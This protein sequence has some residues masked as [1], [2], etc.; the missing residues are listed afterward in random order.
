M[1]RRSDMNAHCVSTRLGAIVVLLLSSAC[2]VDVSEGVPDD[3]GAEPTITQGTPGGRTGG[4]EC[5][6]VL[7]KD[8]QGA[9]Y[10]QEYLCPLPDRPI[11]DP[12]EGQALENLDN[13]WVSGTAV[14][15]PH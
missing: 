12:S 4:T 2:A 1:K 6:P 3:N 5:M 14:S 13:E 10:L 11:P 15:T 7:A 9:L 8:A